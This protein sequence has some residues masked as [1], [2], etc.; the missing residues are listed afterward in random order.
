MSLPASSGVR[1]PVGAATSVGSLP[2]TDIDDAVRL[3]LGEL[4]D[5]P[6]LPELPARGAGAEMIGRSASV[7]A[8]LQVD[9]QP[10]GWR[11]LAGGARPGHDEQRARDFLSRDLDALQAAA[12]HYVGPLKVQLV[13]PW[14]LAASLELP[15]GGAA[16]GDV[17]ASRDLAEALSEG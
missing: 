10:S 1:W 5:L 12:F 4:P 9:L 16:L 3:V 13:G 6:H 14:T 2:G 8:D 11:L 7:L 17:G 15:R